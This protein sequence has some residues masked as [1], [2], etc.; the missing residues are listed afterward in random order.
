[1]LAGDFVVI[2]SASPQE[3]VEVVAAG[4]GVHRA[5]GSQAAVHDGRFTG[6]LDGP[7]CYGPGKVDRLAAELGSDA[8]ASAVAYADS[9]SDLPLLRGAAE[10]VA[11]N[12]DRRLRHEAERRGW[13]ILRFG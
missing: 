10:A 7:F 4:L 13:P 2:L 3:L 1:V 9:A 6:A 11:V 8:L 12:P 5:V